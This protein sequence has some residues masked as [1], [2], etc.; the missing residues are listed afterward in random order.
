MIDIEM[1][2]AACVDKLRTLVVPIGKRQLA[3]LDISA[4]PPPILPYHTTSLV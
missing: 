3:V 2:G 1:A 4:V